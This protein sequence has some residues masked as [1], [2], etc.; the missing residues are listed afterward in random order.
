MSEMIKI[1]IMGDICPTD[2]YRIFFDSKNPRNL[3]GQVVDRLNEADIAIANLEAPATNSDTPI[4]KCGPNLKAKPQDITLLKDTGIDVLSLANNHILDYGEDAV[5][6]T[7]NVC[8]KEKII[9]VGGGKNET[10]AKEPCYISVKEKKIGVI[11][12]AEAE[13]NLACN[14]KPGAN[15]FDC[16]DSL[17]N[18]RE[19]KSKCDYLLVLYH[20]GVEYYIYPSPL[21][22]KKCRKMVEYGADIVLCQHSHCIGTVEKY[23]N[24]TIVYGQG[25]SVFG[26]QHGNNAWNEG[27]LVEIFIDD[28]A[29]AISLL[30]MN[31]SECGVELADEAASKARI[32]KMNEMSLILNDS[33]RLEDIW[34][35]FCKDKSDLY[36][37]LLYGRGRLFNKFN[38][39]L[40]NR[41]MDLLYSKK[42]K[43]ITMNLVRCESHNEVVQTMLMDSVFKVK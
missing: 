12:F 4:N 7:I 23:N 19:A 26:Y 17:D 5:V 43:M 14:D 25:N 11:S 31:A 1:A 10:E 18:I 16:F 33:T 29:I 30:L 22:Q 32:E 13:F 36:L 27:F 37:P 9:T 8:K 41:L 38:R 34:K 20:G 6:E 42:K 35:Q 3:L 21:L 40:H 39:I 2:D 15:H 28:T 24:S